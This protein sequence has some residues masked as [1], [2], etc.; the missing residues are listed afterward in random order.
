MRAR[1]LRQLL[2]W[3]LGLSIYALLVTVVFELLEDSSNVNPPAGNNNPLLQEE[4]G[5][6]E[7]LL[8]EG[9]GG[10]T[11]AGGVLLPVGPKEGL[12]PGSPAVWREFLKAKE[13]VGQTLSAEGFDGQQTVEKI[14]EFARGSTA[15]LLLSGQPKQVLRSLP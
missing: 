13:F 14:E 12:L 15:E 6:M 10:E 7:V 2:A 11:L 5:R 4:A 9:A 3:G 1:L 8:K